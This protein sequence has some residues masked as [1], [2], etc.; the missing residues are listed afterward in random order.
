MNVIEKCKLIDKTEI[1]I[2]NLLNLKKINNLI[3]I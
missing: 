1:R 3:K 2:E